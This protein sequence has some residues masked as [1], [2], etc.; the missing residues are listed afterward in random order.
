MKLS[1]RK[2]T[3]TKIPIPK[4]KRKEKVQESQESKNRRKDKKESIRVASY[5]TSFASDL[6]KIMGSEKHFLH[7]A[8]SLLKTDLL[9]T[10][11]TFAKNRIPF[12]N[13]VEFVRRFFHEGGGDVI[14]LQEIVN[15]DLKKGEPVEKGGIGYILEQLVGQPL[16][17]NPPNDLEFDNENR[18]LRCF[19]LTDYCYSF[20]TV[21][22]QN[23]TEPTIL[24]IWKKKYYGECVYMDGMDLQDGRPIMLTATSEGFVFINLHAPNNATGTERYGAEILVYVTNSIQ[25]LINNYM[26]NKKIK[27]IPHYRLYIMGDFNERFN[28]LRKGIMLDNGNIPSIKLRCFKEGENLR[29]NSCCYNFDSTHGGIPEDTNTPISLDNVSQKYRGYLDTYKYTGDYVFGEAVI[30]NM[31]IYRPKRHYNS[32]NKSGLS[33]ESDHEMVWAEFKLQ[34][35]PYE[36]DDF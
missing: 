19:C 15:W 10:L 13:A 11:K 16:V 2:D 17:Y 27:Y 7:N 22:T 24:T 23:G 14:G 34:P 3:N 9:Q 5:N 21:R 1:W 12:K 28:V 35:H 29:V 36:D 31:K 30:E 4:N 18:L 33:L 6:G 25:N 20:L 8:N 26:E 32:E